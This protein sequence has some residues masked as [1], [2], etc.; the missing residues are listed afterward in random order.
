MLIGTKVLPMG[1]TTCVAPRKV[2]PY[3]I[4]HVLIYYDCLW[5]MIL[6]FCFITYVCVCEYNI[7]VC[8]CVFNVKILFAIH[9]LTSL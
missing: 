2:T 9:R 3:C 8:V 7:R 5:S 1:N 4:K 6:G